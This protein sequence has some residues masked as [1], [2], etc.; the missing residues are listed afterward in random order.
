MNW[1]GWILM[2][3]SITATTTLLTWCLWKILREPTRAEH[4]HSQ[5]DIDPHDRDE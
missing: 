2:I 3:G 4:I 1:Q 5:L